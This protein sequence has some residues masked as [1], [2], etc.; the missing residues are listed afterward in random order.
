MT[1]HDNNP[2]WQEVAERLFGSD[3]IAP[4]SEVLGVNR[5]TVERWRSG[6]VSAP[7]RVADE[8][9][10]LARRGRDNR[11]YGIMLRRAATGESPMAIRDA[12]QALVL[13]VLDEVPVAMKAARDSDMREPCV[14]T[15]AIDAAI[16]HAKETGATLIK[17]SGR[18]LA[19]GCEG[20]EHHIATA[21]DAS[22]AVPADLTRR[23]KDWAN[24]VQ[25]LIISRGHSLMSVRTEYSGNADV[26]WG[27]GA[28]S[29][30]ILELIAAEGDGDRS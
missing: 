8:I 24:G 9:T 17:V 15:I 28:L 2:D 13:D 26:L 25:A 3:W 29:K 23:A 1:N 10:D 7:D 16:S 14:A 19:P 4:L 21:D 11:N 20:R 5:R 12:A 6:A 22:T 18:I 27:P 30:R